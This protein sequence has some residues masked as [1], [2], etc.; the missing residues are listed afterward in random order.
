[1]LPKVDF[2]SIQTFIFLLYSK[3]MQ[4]LSSGCWSVDLGEEFEK[5]VSVFTVGG[6]T[7]GRLLFFPTYFWKLCQISKA[8]HKIE[9]TLLG[10][11]LDQKQTVEGYRGG[12]CV[13]PISVSC[14]QHLLALN[15]GFMTH[16]IFDMQCFF[17]FSEKYLLCFLAIPTFSGHSH[18]R[19]S[20]LYRDRRKSHSFTA[21]VTFTCLLLEIINDGTR[22]QNKQQ[23]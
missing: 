3:R 1:M 22:M 23:K 5:A 17:F 6:Q 21:Y 15:W 7:S 12:D 4:I 11:F 14:N 20:T 19:I 2:R 13:L 16:Q 18:D 8:F 10:K 9:T